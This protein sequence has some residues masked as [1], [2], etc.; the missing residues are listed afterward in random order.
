M[1]SWRALGMPTLAA[2]I[3]TVLIPRLAMLNVSVIDWDESIYALIG[4]QWV[5]GHVPHQT[6]FDH[7]P[8][9]LYAIFAAFFVAFGDT[10]Q[11]IRLI[12]IVFVAATACLLARLAQI[13]GPDR[14]LGGV[15]AA[16]YGLLTLTN[17]GLA[18]N[19]E[20]LVN[21]FVVLSGYLIV[22][23]RLDLRESFPASLAVGASMGMALQ[24]NYLAAILLAGIVGF[25]LACMAPLQPKTR[26]LRRVVVNGTYMLCGFLLVSIAI[27]LPVLLY[28]NL[29]DYFAL[30]LRYLTGYQGVDEPG[31][32]LRRISEALTPYWPFYTLTLVLLAS[33]LRRRSTAQHSS[34]SGDALAERRVVA[35]IVLCAFALLAAL[36]SRRFYQHFFLFS[37]PA[38]VMLAVAFL[39][40][41][42]PQGRLRSLLAVWMLLMASVSIID[43]RD[44]L[45][46]GMRSHARIF[47]GAPADSIAE[48]GEYLAKRLRPGEAIYVHDGQPI[49]YFMTRTVPLTRF[50][51]PDTH[52][53]SEVAGRLGFTPYDAVEAIL[54]R[55]PR[56]I[57]AGP[58][59]ANTE[60][61]NAA[62]LLRDTLDRDYV[63]VSVGDVGAPRGIYERTVAG[64]RYVD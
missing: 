2:I 38:L 1:P 40:M 3:V 33:A 20:I 26:L 16:L 19:T 5:E 60:M 10:I 56:F 37:V 35:W 58:L 30:K 12:P 22:F 9:G 47:E 41:A 48:V 34:D 51:F 50:A 18:T 31:V 62:I 49:L 54:E 63:P 44:Q 59:S 13:P 29:A 55:E 23:H 36:A 11:A 57:I 17:G 32:A 27:H 6:V 25:Y 39:R 52:L 28:G 15:A 64:T 4:Q 46:R 45:V 42:V 14:M 53:K 8:I 61:T 43:A 7:K 24:V 21:F